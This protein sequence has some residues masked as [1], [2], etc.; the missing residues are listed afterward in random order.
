[1]VRVFLQKS[2]KESQASAACAL[3]DEETL[4]LCAGMRVAGIPFAALAQ[5][6]PTGLAQKLCVLAPARAG[7]WHHVEWVLVLPE[8]APAHAGCWHRVGLLPTLQ[9]QLR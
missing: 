9:K 8:P 2:V 1:M 5:A 4:F 7:C 6:K 3:L